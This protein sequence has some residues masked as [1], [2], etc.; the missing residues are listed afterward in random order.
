MHNGA[1]GKSSCHVSSPAPRGI[2]AHGCVRA[3]TISCETVDFVAQ[4][5]L[6]GTCEV[7]CTS[8]SLILN[9]P[10]VA[11]TGFLP[12]VLAS[13]LAWPPWAESRSAC[14]HKDENIR[15]PESKEK[16]PTLLGTRALC[17][18]GSSSGLAGALVHLYTLHTT[19][20]SRQNPPPLHGH[21]P[22]LT[23][24]S[25]SWSS[26]FRLL[27][28]FNYRISAQTNLLK[29]TAAPSSQSNY[30]CTVC[31]QS[32]WDDLSGNYLIRDLK[33]AT[34]KIQTLMAI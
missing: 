5:L 23:I 4:W 18:H 3:P 1:T 13:R 2:S 28:H 26:S 30:I 29:A 6:P 32:L 33:K 11:H 31:H 24:L 27:W 17:V 21:W 12:G 25:P 34:Y 9:C 15:A 22:C 10:R 19:S 20:L 16:Y 14:G 7:Q 8:Q